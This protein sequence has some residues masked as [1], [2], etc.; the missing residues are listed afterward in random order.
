MRV[1]RVG[2]VTFILGAV[3]GELRVKLFV[4]TLIILM[5]LG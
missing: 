2:I 4:D 1:L 3:E 5:R